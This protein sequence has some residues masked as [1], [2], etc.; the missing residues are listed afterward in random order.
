MWLCNSYLVILICGDCYELCLGVDESPEGGILQFHDVTGT[1]KM[2]PRL[3]FVHG[4]QNRLKHTT[5]L[6]IFNHF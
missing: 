5:K 3:V 6:R 1:Y 4:V 2:E